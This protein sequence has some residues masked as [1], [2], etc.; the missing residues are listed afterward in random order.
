MNRPVF[1]L[2]A[3]LY[4]AN[5]SAQ[6]ERVINVPTS[7]S[8]SSNIQALLHLPSDYTISTNT[9]PL[10]IFCHS[11]SE[12]VDGAS[13]GTG[14]AKIYNQ[15]LYGGPPY[16]IEHGAWPTSFR[17]P[18]SG[19]Q[20][21]FIVV[22]PQSKHW[23]ISGDQLAFVIDY[24]VATYRVDVNRIHI[25]GVSA[26]GGTIVQY[27]AHLDVNENTPSLTTRVRKWKAASMVPMSDALNNSS[28]K[29]IWGDIIAADI[30]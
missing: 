25:T 21:Q 19:M 18:Y 15:A 29:Q 28:P 10:I 14:L 4:F 2:I 24:I 11:A 8:S 23:Q 26:G 13:T 9:Y 1:A 6:V 12:A 7:T 16:F 27:A 30:R 20:E 3:I 22:S 5:A 17:N